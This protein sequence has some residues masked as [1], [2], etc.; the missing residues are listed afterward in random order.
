MVSHTQPDS[1]DVRR[2]RPERIQRAY[3]AISNFKAEMDACWMEDQGVD[4]KISNAVVARR[5]TMAS[6]EVSECVRDA[7]ADIWGVHG[8]AIDPEK[9]GWIKTM[10]LG[11]GGADVHLHAGLMRVFVVTVFPQE[12]RE[13]PAPNSHPDAF[14][15][16]QVGDVITR[17]QRESLDKGLALL[18]SYARRH[19]L[20][21]THQPPSRASRVVRGWGDMTITA[22]ELDQCIVEIIKTFWNSSLP[23]T[24]DV[25]RGWRGTTIADG[26]ELGRVGAAA[27]ADLGLLRERILLPEMTEAGVLAKNAKTKAE[28][29]RHA[30]RAANLDR[31]QHFAEYFRFQIAQV[32]GQDAWCRT[33]PWPLLQDMDRALGGDGSE[34]RVVGLKRPPRRS[35]AAR[36]DAPT[37]PTNTIAAVLLMLFADADPEVI[38]TA[39]QLAKAMHTKRAPVTARK[40]RTAVCVLRQHGWIINKRT[41]RGGG[42]RLDDS[43]R[44]LANA[45]LKPVK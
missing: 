11:D 34:L 38:R 39:E 2:I 30:A 6:S 22:D 23:I 3:A 42:Y 7:L 32:V 8:Q 25:D 36:D 21:L 44:A 33:V 41:A 27:D 15:R 13:R 14:D 20:D 19:G 28:R 35:S 18:E 40:V 5:L 45:L 24:V 10:A 1:P 16:W 37:V 4:F 17:E 9:T 31:Q 43:Q 26:K 29:E 12:T